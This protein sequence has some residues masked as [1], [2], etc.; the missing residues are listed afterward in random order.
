M[1]TL[2]DPGRRFVQESLCRRV[3]LHQ[4]CTFWWTKHCR[5][6][7]DPSHRSQW[8]HPHDSKDFEALHPRQLSRFPERLVLPFSNEVILSGYEEFDSSGTDLFTS[9]VKM[10]EHEIP[11]QHMVDIEKRTAEF[12]EAS[13]R[14][15]ATSSHMNSSNKRFATRSIV[16]KRLSIYNWTPSVNRRCLPATNCRNVAHHYLAG[17]VGISWPRASH[18]SLPRDPLRRLPDSLQLGHLLPQRWCQVYLPS[19]HKTRFAWSSRGKKI[20]R[21]VLHGF[22][23]CATFRRPLVSGQKYFTVL[24]PHISNIYA[25]KKCISKKL[26]LTFRVIMSYFQGSWLGCRWLQVYRM[27]APRQ[28]QLQYHWLIYGQYLAYAT[29]PHTTVETWIHSGQLGR[30]LRISNHLILTVSGKCMSMVHS[31]SHGKHLAEDQMIKVAI[32]KHG[33]I[34][35]SSTG[36]TRGLGKMRTSHAFHWKNAPQNSHTEIPRDASAKSWATT[37]SHLNVCDHSHILL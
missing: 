1:E 17:G 4:R 15:H 33:F 6:S 26:I 36:A 18:E 22:L 16:Q 2:L 12:R 34:W 32:T 5:G 37:R 25:I 30:R 13:E 7:H 9:W 19:W 35:T 28:R 8:I 21:W 10:S 23:L 20:G 3:G 31:P 11:V 27:A 29:G 14:K 24:S